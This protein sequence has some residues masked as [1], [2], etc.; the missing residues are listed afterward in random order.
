VSGIEPRKISLS[1]F[2]ASQWVDCLTDLYVLHPAPG[3]APT[4]PSLYERF[5]SWAG[6]GR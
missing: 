5:F 1:L 3:A 6:L 2:L 4:L